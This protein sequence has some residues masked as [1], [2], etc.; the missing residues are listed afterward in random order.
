MDIIIELKKPWKKIAYGG[1]IYTK[2]VSGI[3][4][5]WWV[6]SNKNKYSCRGSAYTNNTCTT[7]SMCIEHSHEQSGDYV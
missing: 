2:G 1:Y 4:K 5:I 3:D 6:C 7:I